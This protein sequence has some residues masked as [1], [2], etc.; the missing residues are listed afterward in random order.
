MRISKIVC[1]RCGA[2]IKEHPN[3]IF[4][5]VV[6][7]ETGDIKVGTVRAS[8]N[9]ELMNYDFCDE[10]TEE[11]IKFAKTKPGNQVVVLREPSEDEMVDIAEAIKEELE[12]TIPAEEPAEKKEEPKKN[13]PKVEPPKKAE[14]ITVKQPSVKDLVLQGLSKQEVCRITGCKP[15][16]YDQTKY[17]LK[18]KGLLPK[19]DGDKEPVKCSEVHDTCEYGTRPK[20]SDVHMCD[21]IGMTG[22]MRTCKP[23]E[24]IAYKRKGKV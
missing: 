14:P 11:I 22:H 24:C 6:D 18:K 21:Y 16:T 9:G 19:E 5:E 13:L 23:E 20:G 12:V 1:D 7:R 4:P 10:C 17:Q 8:W 3:K 2:D 15:I